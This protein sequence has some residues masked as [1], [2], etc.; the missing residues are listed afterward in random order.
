MKIIG[1]DEGKGKPNAHS[2]IV[3][4]LQDFIKSEGL[5]DCK[6]NKKKKKS[7]GL[8]KDDTEHRKKSKL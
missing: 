3:D 5:R 4:D 1:I 7:A 8:R 6:A 2:D